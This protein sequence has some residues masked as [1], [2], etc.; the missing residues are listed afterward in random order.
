M[1]RILVIDDEA[2]IRKA[3]QI[4]LTSEEFEVDLASDGVSGIHLGQQGSY[5]VLI[6]DL[7][8]PDMNG[9]DVIKQ[10]KASSPSI[11]PII[12]TGKGSMQSSLEAIRLEV[13]DY[14]EK[15]LSLAAIKSAI[16]RCLEKRALTAKVAETRARQKLLSDSLTGLPDR[17]QFIDRLEHALNREQ[18]HEGAGFAHILI[19]IDRFKIVNEVYGHVIGDKVLIEVASRLRDCIATTDIAARMNGDEFAVLID[20]ADNYDMVMAE[21]ERIKGSIERPIL[22]DDTKINLTISVGIVMRRRFYESSDDVFR[23]AEMALSS[24]KNQ[25]GG[26]IKVFEKTMLEQAVESL[27]FEN[28]LQIG[29][30]NQEFFLSYQPIIELQDQRCAGFEALIR[31]KHPERG[32]L[33]P[34][35]F[36][37]K[38]ENC[39]LIDQIGN[40]VLNEACRQIR[41]WQ[42]G[43]SN[44]KNIVININISVS[45]FLQPRFVNVLSGILREH[46]INPESIKLELTESVLME[47]S[48]ASI[49]I[50]NDIRAAGIK[51]AIDDFGTGYSALSYIQRFPLDDLK[52]GESFIRNIASDTE[53]Y[54]IVKTIVDLSKTLGLNVVAEGVENEEQLK[55]IKSLNIDMAQ[56][57]LFSTPVDTASAIKF[58][59]EFL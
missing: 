20:N 2:S 26:L 11:I 25:G 59:E 33:S 46:G 16:A 12:I 57:Y 37:P 15:P 30:K 36:I 40:W 53:C 28:E 55:K 29:I 7:C 45:Q 56:G 19:G 23:D 6:A 10:I 31:W 41:E 17:S 51:I 5:D 43:F 18:A 1:E 39:G 27:Q 35:D 49:K 8:L 52:I 32:I 9:L 4:G 13:S 48:D 24:C 38:A 34:N 44:H 22:V 58:M 54:E 50:L 14:I 47:N 3:L 21:A 42:N